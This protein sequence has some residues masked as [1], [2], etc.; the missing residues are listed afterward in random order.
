MNRRT[1]LRSAG[2]GALA[3]LAGCVEG[4]QSYYQGRVR[5]RIPIEIT[6]ESDRAQNIRLEAYEI[7]TDRQTYDE[8]YSVRSNELVH[9]PHLDEIEQRFRVIRFEGEESS[10]VDTARISPDAQLVL[11]T[12]YEDDVEL[13]VVYDEDEAQNESAEGDENATAGNDANAS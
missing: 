2:V 12:V 9:P 7:G 5:G 3:G 4:I 10:S 6:N 11:I 8:N 1:V 13:E